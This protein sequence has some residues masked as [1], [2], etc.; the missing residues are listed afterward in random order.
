MQK[1]DLQ[2]RARELRKQGKTYDEI[3]KELSVS[4]SSVSN[5]V[6]D[7]ELTEQQ[8]QKIFGRWKTNYK[9]IGKNVSNGL[10]EY[11]KNNDVYYNYAGYLI[12]RG[13]RV[14]RRMMEEYLGREL[15]NDEDVH[16]INGIKDDNRIENLVV[17]S[18]REHTLLHQGAAPYTIVTCAYCKKEFGM[19]LSKYNFK[20][21]SRGNTNICCSHSCRAKFNWQ[22]RHQQSVPICAL[23]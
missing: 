5:W 18:K 12:D 22:N 6:R 3:V 21:K 13:G 1:P 11:Y 8:Q 20:I 15:T 7:V 14:H 23:A 16:H 10:K 19:K 4:K 2:Y 17:M 9:E